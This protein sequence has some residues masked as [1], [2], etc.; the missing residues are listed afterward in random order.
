V[1]LGDVA[2]KGVPAALLMA[3]LSSDA[4]F[5][6]LT[7]KE[8]HVAV[9][10]LNDLLA[11]QTSQMDRF[12]TLAAA[13]VDTATHRVRLVNAGHPSPLLYRKATGRIEEATPNAVVG[14]PLGV[15]EGFPYD[16]C[17]V[18]LDPGDLLLVFTDGVTD[19]RDTADRDFHMKGVYDVLREGP[20]TPKAVGDRLVKAVKLHA[21]GCKQYDDITVVCFGRDA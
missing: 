7:E 19:A 5:C 8:P 3:K 21:S 9:N 11:P 2:G 14:L 20:H 4:R 16:S 1:A 13:L 10:K 15:A 17:E 12:V 18:A 6:L